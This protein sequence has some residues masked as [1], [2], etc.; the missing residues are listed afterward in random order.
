[1]QHMM[2]FKKVNKAWGKCGRFNLDSVLDDTNCTNA[3]LPKC[4][5]C[6]ATFVLRRYTLESL[7]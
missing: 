4:D 7:R 3:K 6:M 2:V 1:M 5:N